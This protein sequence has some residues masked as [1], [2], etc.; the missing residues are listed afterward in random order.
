MSKSN[1]GVLDAA[2]EERLARKALTLS[3]ER[4]QHELDKW[5]AANSEY[6]IGDIVVHERVKG[7][8][9]ERRIIEERWRVTDISGR[10]CWNSKDIEIELH[11]VWILK[12]GST[13]KRT[14]S[15]GRYG[16]LDE[17]SKGKS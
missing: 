11:C 3:R 15:F 4:L 6:S 12:D 13:G 1:Q 5:A 17:I 2:K 8:G 10:L 7:W 16:R 9:S 14:T